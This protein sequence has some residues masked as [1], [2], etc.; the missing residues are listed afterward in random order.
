MLHGIRPEAVKRAAGDEITLMVEGVVNGGMSGK[1][2][3]GT[4]SRI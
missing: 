1:K 2:A 4:A 3:L